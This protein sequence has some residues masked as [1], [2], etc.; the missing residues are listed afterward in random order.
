MKCL[1]IGLI[2]KAGIG[3]D[4]VSYQQAILTNFQS[5]KASLDSPKE[6]LTSL[7]DTLVFDLEEYW[8]KSKG[9]IEETEESKVL[10]FEPR[11]NRILD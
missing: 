3:L 6:L 9:Q 5:L 11:R 2:D 1:V 4:F 7:S 10:E 8:G